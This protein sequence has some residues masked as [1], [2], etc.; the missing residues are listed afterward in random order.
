MNVLK[1]AIYTG[2]VASHQTKPIE[3]MQTVAEALYLIAKLLMAWNTAELPS[4][5]DYRQRNRKLVEPPELFF[6]NIC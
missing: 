2:R 4:V 3:E 5:W 1:R 6:V